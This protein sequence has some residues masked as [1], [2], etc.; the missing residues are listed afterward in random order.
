MRKLCGFILLFFGLEIYTLIQVGTRLGLFWLFALL[1]FG[2]VAGL[3][4][5]SL[6]RA[7]ALTALYGQ[8]GKMRFSGML[9]VYL[10]GFL[11]IFPGLL[12]DVLALLL[13][14]PPVQAGLARRFAGTLG[15]FGFKTASNR[16]WGFGR[17][18]TMAR[19]PG[20]RTEGGGRQTF[21]GGGFYAH[22]KD[23]PVGPR[24]IPADQITII[25]VEPEQLSA[26]SRKKA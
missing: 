7:R 16:N 11:L 20:A 6:Q 4:L 14:L 18:F 19:Y 12:S 2:L 22:D 10:A 8:G 24:I 26:A 25:D 15:S 5:F 1:L 17:V 21:E 23:C 3:G 13:L 9:C